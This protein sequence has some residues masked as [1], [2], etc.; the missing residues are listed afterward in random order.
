MVYSTTAF[1]SRLEQMEKLLKDDFKVI[2]ERLNTTDAILIKKEIKFKLVEQLQYHDIIRQKIEHV[3]AFMEN[4]R[5]A[6][7]GKKSQEILTA[8]FLKMCLSL[9]QH[10]YLEYKE[11]II[12]THQLLKESGKVK[13]EE[14]L[15]SAFELEINQI[16]KDLKTQYLETDHEDDESIV[17][18]NRAKY[19]GL[20]DSFSMQSERNV[21]SMLFKEDTPESEDNGESSE[22][23]VE[24]F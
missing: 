15:S 13:C 10:T 17:R 5:G 14:E 22:G 7:K 9:L 12:Q 6:E 1:I 16:I 2:S 21:F 18:K 23:Q 19:K 8:D 11:V 3:R 20:W 24:L 4:I